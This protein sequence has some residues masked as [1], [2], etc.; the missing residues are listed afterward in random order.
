MKSDNAHRWH[1]RPPPAA[2]LL[3]PVLA[4]AVLT[5]FAWPAAKV[6]PRDLPIA[7][8][9]PPPAAQAIEQQLAL[10]TGAFEVHRYTDL[11]SAREA[12][13]DRKVYG[14]FAAAEGGPIVLNS[15]AASP[16]VAQLLAHAATEAGAARVQDVAPASR[17]G[18]ALPASVLPLGLVGIVTGL[19]GMLL[20]PGAVGRSGLVLGGSLLAGAAAGLILQS[21]LEV[22]SGDWLANA[23]ALSLTVL[24]IAA[25]VAGLGALFGKA[26]LALAALTMVLI[27]NPFSGA[28]TAPELLPEP[29]GGLG[30]LLPPGAGANLLRS[31][32]FFDGAGAG[33]HLIVLAAWAVAGLAA[34][35]LPALRAAAGAGR[36]PRSTSLL[37]SESAV[38]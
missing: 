11:R 23:A 1:R 2:I 26:G 7:V 17:A 37:D 24:A 21:W 10:Q 4:A 28:G 16:A 14:A 3:V 32:G 27:G 25:S 33:D 38:S 22:V 29:V 20:L 6:A 8:A 34:I 5:L 35:A 30:Q 19:A 31:T 18:G 15:T 13:R 9:G 36:Q 12:I